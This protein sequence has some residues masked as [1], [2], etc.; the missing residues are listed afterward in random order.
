MGVVLIVDDD[1]GLRS[2]FERT[3]KSLGHRAVT[4]DGVDAA[5]HIV[6]AEPVDL[7]LTDWQ[8]EPRD[9]LALLDALRTRAPA[10]PVVLMS[11][12]LSDD[13]RDEALRIGAIAAID[14]PRGF[15]WLRSSLH[16]VLA[17]AKQEHKGDHQ[18]PTGEPTTGTDTVL[19]RVLVVEDD[20]DIREAI[21]LVVER[22][23]CEP[24]CVSHGLEALRYLQTCDRLPSVILLDLMMP[25]MD[26]WEFL[27]RRDERAQAIPVVVITAGATSGLPENVRCLRKPVSVD[28]LAAELR[29]CWAPVRGSGRHES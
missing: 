12:A 25:V 18:A 1:A 24:I 6:G 29:P 4:A 11:G 13:V 5:L 28:V 22:Q 2:V 14:K 10:L 9:G 3:V 15:Q 20:E 26:G 23:G 16:V 21:A 8:M 17:A 19:P 7:V 27:R